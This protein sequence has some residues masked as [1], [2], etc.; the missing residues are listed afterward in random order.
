MFKKQKK[1]AQNLAC[2]ATAWN[3]L[4]EAKG[5]GKPAAIPFRLENVNFEIPVGSTWAV[6][7]SVGAGKSSLLHALLGEMER[8]MVPASVVELHGSTAFAP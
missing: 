1:A 8:E 4:R 3:I 6:V 2:D 5:Y 7:G